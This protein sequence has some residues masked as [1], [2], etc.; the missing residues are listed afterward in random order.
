MDTIPC[1][2]YALQYFYRLLVGKMRNKGKI[3]ERNNE[4]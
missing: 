4:K 2:S 1:I 3:I